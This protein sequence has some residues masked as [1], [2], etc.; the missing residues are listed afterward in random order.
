MNTTHRLRRRKRWRWGLAVLLL[1]PVLGVGSVLLLFHLTGRPACVPQLPR[2]AGDATPDLPPVVIPDTLPV[3]QP[4]EWAYYGPILESGAEGEWDMLWGGLTPGSVVKKDGIY[5]FYYV[6]ADGYRSFDGGPR[7]RSVGVATSPDGIHFTKYEGNPVM[8][9]RPYDGEEEGANSAAVTLD[10]SGRFVM[11]YGAAAGRERIIVSDGRV[12]YSDDGLNFVDS[13]RV[14]YHCDL[15]VYGWGDELFPAAVTQQDGRWFLFYLPNGRLPAANTLGA[16]W[17]STLETMDHSRGVLR[18]GGN[19]QP[20]GTWGNIVPLPNGQLAFF[21]Q[22]LWWPDTFV[23]VRLANAAAPYHLSEPIV[24]YD[25]PNLKRGVAFLDEER[26]TWF[27]YTNDFDA[28]WDVYLAPYGTPDTTPPTAPLD[29][30]STALTYHT[31]ALTWEAATDEDTGVVQYHIY[32]DGQ[33]LGTTKTLTW[34]DTGLRELVS[35]TYTV[36]AINFHGAE[37]DAA[38]TTITTPADTTPPAI[39]SASTDGALDRVQVTFDEPVDSIAATEVSHYAIDQGIEVHQA[40]LDSE[41]RTVTLITMPHQAQQVYTLTVQGV[42]DRAAQ[43]VGMRAAAN[44]TYLADPIPGLVGYWPLAEIQ[45]DGTLADQSGY[46]HS[47]MAQHLWPSAH[48]TGI[49]Q[50]DGQASTVQIIPDGNLADLT[51]SSFTMLASV[52]PDTLPTTPNG[53][54]L[55]GRVGSYPVP[56]VGLHYTQD[57]RFQ[58]QLFHSDETVT[59]LHASA[60]APGAWYHLAMVVDS[61][62]QTFQLYVNGQAVADSTPTYQEPLYLFGAVP[63]QDDRYGAYFVGSNIPFQSAGAY[64]DAY[65]AGVIKEVRFYD[66]PLTTTEVQSFVPGS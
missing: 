44:I 55:V 33:L 9:H 18:D 36:T 7:H 29:L 57:G 62:A 14:L 59:Q 2:F 19:D 40:T 64:Y 50:F 4:D 21:I 27:M 39:I 1:L 37:G 28:D 30:Q 46:A 43:P 13:E 66:R 12:A 47:A 48:E 45:P 60:A 5:Y 52:Y 65:F 8:I 20:V 10:E 63:H 58:A 11:V 54:H 51:T 49:L 22:R 16:V 25:I 17:G 42:L 41:G 34:N 32:R 31:I 6:A 3:P 56:F 15:G 38:A 24:R 53:A 35:V 23:E 26:R 61:V